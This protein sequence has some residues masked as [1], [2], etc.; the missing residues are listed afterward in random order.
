MGGDEVKDSDMV[1]ESSRHIARET[2]KSAYSRDSDRIGR[3]EIVNDG[4]SVD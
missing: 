2:L 3:T 4:I 1:M